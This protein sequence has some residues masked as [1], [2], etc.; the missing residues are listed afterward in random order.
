MNA[1]WLPGNAAGVAF[2]E[3]LSALGRICDVTDIAD[4]V[5]FLAGHDGRWITGHKID[6]AGGSQL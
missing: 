1:G 5:G 4:I 6:A 3:S 2:V